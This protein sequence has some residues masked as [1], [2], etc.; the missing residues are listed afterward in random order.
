MARTTTGI[1]IGRRAAKLLRGQFKG[2]TFHVS[3][4]AFG[5]NA[6]GDILRGWQGIEL[7]FKPT[8]ARIGLTGRDVNLR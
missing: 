1:D 3:D 2:G 5:D 6:S 4:F 7:D 8:A